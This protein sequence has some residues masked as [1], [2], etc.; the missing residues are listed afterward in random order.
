[1]CHEYNVSR[2]SRVACLTTVVLCSLR[3]HTLSLWHGNVLT[4]LQSLFLH[5]W[6]VFA[7]FS[8][9][10]KSN[11]GMHNTTNK[12]SVTSACPL[13]R[14]RRSCRWGW[15][16]GWGPCTWRPCRGTPARA[17]WPGTPGSTPGLEPSHHISGKEKAEGYA[18]LW[19]TWTQP[20]LRP[21]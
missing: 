11:E 10:D 13:W 6:Q 3:S 21:Q 7:R 17:S 18:N 20:L 15:R 5:T 2:V 1:M 4:Q 12:S 14:W 8:C 9:F 19:L 16:C